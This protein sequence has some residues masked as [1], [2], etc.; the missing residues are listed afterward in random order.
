MPDAGQNAL[1]DMP[2]DRLDRMT[3]QAA[4]VRP[5]RADPGRGNHQ[6]G[7]D[8]DVRGDVAPAAA[9]L[10]CA[11]MLLPGAATG[12]KGDDGTAGKRWSTGSRR[13]SG[14]GAGWRASQPA[15]RGCR[16]A[17]ARSASPAPR[18]IRKPPHRP[19]AP[20]GRWLP[21]S[22]LRETQSPRGLAPPAGN[23]PSAAAEPVADGQRASTARL[24]ERGGRPMAPANDEQA[25]EKAAAE[26][27]RQG[28]SRHR[29]S[30]LAGILEAVKRESR[31]AWILLGNATVDSVEGGV[32]TVRFARKAR[33]R[34]SRPGSTRTR[35][36]R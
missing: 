35:P 28:R 25:T 23:E 15:E 29:R 10:M 22:R 3:N 32:L 26:R 2:A 18:G 1:L 8:P 36:A 6:R 27:G 31:V 9:E 19:R 33:P 14:W 5:G 7:P 13:N 34:G 24:A 30:A 21:H 4:R 11:Q 16:T 20:P 17:A 12:E